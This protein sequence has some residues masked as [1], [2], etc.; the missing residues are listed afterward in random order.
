MARERAKM[1]TWQRAKQFAPFAALTGFDGALREK[2]DEF[3]RE[4]R[5]TLFEDSAA[6]IDLAM[7]SLVK[8]DRVIVIFFDGDEYDE[9]EGTVNLIRNDEQTLKVGDRVIEY[10]S[11]IE[12]RKLNG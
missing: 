5:K 6:E 7:R 3:R 8:G 1:P 10:D 9:A 12:I 2:E 11:I 4:G